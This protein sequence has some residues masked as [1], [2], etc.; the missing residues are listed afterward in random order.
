MPSS[1]F[2]SANE[3][4]CVVTGGGSGIGRALA[5]HLASLGAKRIAVVDM[6][7]DSAQSTVS[8]LPPKVGLAIQAD[9]GSEMDVRRVIIQTEFKCGPIDAFFCNAGVGGSGGPEVSNDEW[10]YIFRVNVMQGVYASRHL[11]P[12]FETRGRG[13]MVITASSAGLLNLPGAIPYSV[14]KHAA[15]GLAEGLNIMYASKGIHVACLCPMGVRTGMLGGTDGG[16][17]KKD[18]ILSPDYVA[19]ET[20]SAVEKGKFMILPHKQVKTYLVG[21]ARFHEKWLNQMQH[22]HSKFGEAMRNSPN[23]STARL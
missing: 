20:V 4:V 19:K 13:L 12:K 11:F 3:S 10:D 17:M 9:C 22:A 15:V 2:F 1:N 23:M 8:L 16:V 14:T 7:L 5:K 21:K 18:G 6:Y